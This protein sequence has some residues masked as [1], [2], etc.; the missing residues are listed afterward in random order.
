[1]P[2]L[3]RALRDTVG[4]LPP[5][6]WWLW[7]GTLVNRIGAF[8]VPF[9]A[10]YLTGGLHRSV[11]YAGLVL[12]LLGLG[13]TA[14]SLAGGALADRVGRRPT[15]LGAQLGTAVSLVGLGLVHGDVAVAG[16][17]LLYGFFSNATRPAFSA[18]MTD[19]VAPQDRVR[20][21]SLNYWAINLGF[22]IAPVLA[23]FLAQ[24]S[25]LLLFLGDALTTLVLAAIVFLRVPETHPHLPRRTATPDAPA[26]A[27]AQPAG[28][29][30]D[31]VRDP[32]F[33]AFTGLAF[34]LALVFMQ[35]LSTLPVAMAADG[36]TPAQY[37]TAVA[38]NGLLIV[39]LTVP[40]T[41]W[42]TRF[43]RSRVLAVAAVLVGGGFALTA[44]ADSW[45]AYAGTVVVWTLGEI[46][47][48]PVSSAVVADLAPS[49]ARGR[50]QGVYS[51]AWGAASFLAPL[52]GSWV[53]D[54][55]GGATLWVACGL[56]GVLAGV[57]QLLVAPARG[58]RLS[59]LRA[60]AAEASTSV[61]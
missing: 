14:A 36:L 1:M 3:Q 15:L 26:A 34:L 47:N 50:Y 27:A 6:Y 13:G 2:R 45:G 22:A 57:G 44:V 28:S 4:G 46:L 33:M 42:L 52:L 48:A 30:L 49:H 29:F 25:Y 41:A 17:A 43:A 21:F 37:G 19:V 24:V 39:L 7:T 60:L 32:V 59:A 9:L 53:Y 55:A 5:V 56:L 10:I 23:G 35:H 12:A 16:W 54:A 38:V 20:A 58:R 31:A 51:F 40:A 11:S 18:T 8:V 61:A